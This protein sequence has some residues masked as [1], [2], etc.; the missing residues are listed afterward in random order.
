[1]PRE[2]RRVS[3]PTGVVV[4]LLA[5][6]EVWVR[7]DG[8]PLEPE[9]LVVLVEAREREES[10][11]V[12]VDPVGVDGSEPESELALELE[13]ELELDWPDGEREMADAVEGVL[14]TSEDMPRVTIFIPL[15]VEVL[16]GMKRVFWLFAAGIEMRWGWLVWQHPVDS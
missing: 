14:V 1:M 8:L 7:D 16:A 11:D 12:G 2:V 3:V 10:W 5:R 4:W 9:V 13:L 15:L 6:E